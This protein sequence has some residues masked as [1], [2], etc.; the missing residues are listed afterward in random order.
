MTSRRDVRKRES[1]LILVLPALV[2]TVL[3]FQ[4]RLTGEEPAPLKPEQGLPPIYVCPPCGC[5]SDSKTFDAP[6]ECPDCHMG[7][8]RK[9]PKRPPRYVAL[10]VFNGVELLDFAGPGEVFSAAMGSNGNEFQA[11]TVARHRGN[12]SQSLHGHH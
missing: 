5:A 3:A 9:G 2:L 4:S 8:V 7:L 6:G 12:R 11:F 10:V 1:R